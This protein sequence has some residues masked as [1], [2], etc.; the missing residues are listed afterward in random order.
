MAKTTLTL[1]IEYDPELTDPEG[2]AS[3]MDRLMETAL[4]TPDILE[5]Y[6]NPTVG[7]FLIVGENSPKPGPTIVAGI[8]DSGARLRWVLYDL[9]SDCLLTT[10]T[11]DTYQEAADDT[12]LANDVLILQVVIQGIRS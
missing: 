5:E 6:G 8:H 7:E 4:S 11:Y 2:L 9:D 3:A 12:S 1:D 10:R